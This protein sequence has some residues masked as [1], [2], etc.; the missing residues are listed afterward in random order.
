[1]NAVDRTAQVL[2]LDTAMTELA[3]VLELDPH[4]MSDWSA[5]APHD[6][7]GVRRGDFVFIH[8]EGKT[9]G[10]EAPMVPR[11]GEIEE[12]VREPPLSP[13]TSQLGGWR[14][15]MTDI[16]NRIAER[17][18]KD[19]SIEE[20]EIQRPEKG[21]PKL[22]W[23]GEVAEVRNNTSLVYASPMTVS[24]IASA[25]R[26]CRRNASRWQNISAA[27]PTAH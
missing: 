9:N 3:S 19:P 1:M 14:R 16:G 12:W 23:F 25:R 7:L 5:V 15:E 20:G 6:G 18:G 2:C 26:Y 24:H 4:G 11:I 22:N 8:K 27:P 10:A 21:N 17:R 13:E